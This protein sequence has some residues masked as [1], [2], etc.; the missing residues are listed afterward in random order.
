MRLRKKIQGNFE[1]QSSWEEDRLQGQSTQLRRPAEKKARTS[2][3]Y[4]PDPSLSTRQ[5]T[6]KVLG[7]TVEDTYFD[8]PSN[9][10]FH[11]LMR[12]QTIPRAAKTI[13]G[14]SGKFTNGI[15]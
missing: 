10:A 9:L 14:L 6:R 3:C 2:Y 4:L 15:F 5:N 11:D 1:R 8:S 12:G 13:L 7:A